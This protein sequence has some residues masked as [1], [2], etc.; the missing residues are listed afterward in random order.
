MAITARLEADQWNSYIMGILGLLSDAPKMLKAAYSTR[1]Y[2]DIIDHFRMEEDPLGDP[3]EPRSD[4]T[5]QLYAAINL[6]A[7]GS[8]YNGIPASSYRPSNKLLQ[9][10]GNLRKSIM[11]GSVDME[12][13]DSHS[14]MIASNV[15]YS[16]EHNYGAPWFNIPQ[17]EFMGLSNRGLDNV[18]QAILDQIQKAGHAI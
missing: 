15:D 7:F 1:G 2:Q 4:F 9:L 17:R 18:M 11:P 8:S 16:G 5:Q 3:W 12:T 10:T 6:G 14:V 13:V